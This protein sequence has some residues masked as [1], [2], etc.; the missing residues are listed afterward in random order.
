MSATDDLRMPG[1]T[2]AA[3]LPPAPAPDIASTAAR[4]GAY[5]WIA[6]RLFEVVGGWV[7]ST[8]EPAIKVHFAGVARRLADQ[9]AAW[10]ERLPRLRE[11]PRVDLVRAPGPTASALLDSLA[12]V[13]TPGERV[14]ALRAVL[15]RWDEVLAAHGKTMTAVR[16]GS[17]GLTLKW[18]RA[19]LADLLNAS[20]TLDSA[21]TVG[22]TT[23]SSTGGDCGPDAFSV[24]G[25]ALFT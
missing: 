16:D 20:A 13:S 17:A 4:L 2:T 5:T 1:E 18:A 8:P 6:S 15:V 3:P 9:A 24:T 7:A 10:H 23:P 14:S 22:T 25:L 19:E 12:Q 11:A 21:V